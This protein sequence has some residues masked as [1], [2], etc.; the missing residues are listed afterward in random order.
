MILIL[1]TFKI[2]A[3]HSSTPVPTIL[4][5]LFFFPQ[6]LPPSKMLYNLLILFTVYGLLL[7]SNIRSSIIFLSILF[8]GKSRESRQGPDKRW[9]FNKH[10]RNDDVSASL[11]DLI[12]YHSFVLC[13]QPLAFLLF[14]K[15]VTLIPPSDLRAHFCFTQNRIF[16]YL[17]IG[18]FV[19]LFREYFPDPTGECVLSVWLYHY[20][21]L[22]KYPVH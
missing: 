7:S 6:D 4:I 18:Y 8:T 2:V 11:P 12:S 1:T 9:S 3:H 14:P 20:S 22:P 15:H 21:L 13:A 19:T 17:H 10:S 16:L 5:Y